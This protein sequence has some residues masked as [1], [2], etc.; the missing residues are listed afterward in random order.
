MRIGVRGYR[1][2]TMTVSSLTPMLTVKNAAT[3]IE[4]Y[5]DAFDAVEQAR[6]ITPTGQMVA[7]MLIEGLRF[8]VVDDD[9]EAFKREP[10]GSRR[11][12]GAHQPHRG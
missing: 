1:L 10:D 6:F 3:A 11:N 12:D 8:Y 2:A 7:E 9:P 4:F 5:R